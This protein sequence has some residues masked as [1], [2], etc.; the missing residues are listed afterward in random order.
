MTD[1]MEITNDA[2]QKMQNMS[3]S[4]LYCEYIAPGKSGNEI[5]KQMA[6]DV[7]DEKRTAPL[8]KATEDS[9]EAAKLSAKAAEESAKA[10]KRLAIIAF[11]S[12]IVAAATLF[13][14]YLF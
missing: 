14:Q 11:A 2:Y 4:E 6:R 13:L 1:I 10:A 5:N 9:A 8:I 3:I 12:L 7:L